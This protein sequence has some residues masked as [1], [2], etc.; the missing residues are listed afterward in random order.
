MIPNVSVKRTPL[1]ISWNAILSVQIKFPSEKLVAEKVSLG[2]VR[3]GAEC[4][5]MG[6][7]ELSEK[8]AKR[9]SASNHT[10]TNQHAILNSLIKKIHFV[11]HNV[12]VFEGS[13][14]R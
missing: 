13:F 5:P 1:G 12:Q 14:S 3:K 11:F 2:E 10:G 7:E 4:R 8:S 6:S 9:R